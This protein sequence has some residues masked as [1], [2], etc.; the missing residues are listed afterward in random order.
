MAQYSIKPTMM[1]WYF[2]VQLLMYWY[3]ETSNEL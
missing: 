2:D 3:F 1:Y